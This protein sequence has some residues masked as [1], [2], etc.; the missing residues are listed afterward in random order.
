MNTI[1]ISGLRAIQLSNRYMGFRTG[2]LIFDGGECCSSALQ[3][4]VS[5]QHELS[6]RRIR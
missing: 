1:G 3:V 6:R 5:S 4:R 2:L